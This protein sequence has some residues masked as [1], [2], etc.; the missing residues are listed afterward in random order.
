MII[1]AES[2]VDEVV[3]RAASTCLGYLLECTSRETTALWVVVVADSLESLGMSLA[4][5]M[6]TRLK[7]RVERNGARRAVHVTTHRLQTSDRKLRRR[8]DVTTR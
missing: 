1:K 5:V 4:V 3:M 8:R 2:K 6:L 7:R